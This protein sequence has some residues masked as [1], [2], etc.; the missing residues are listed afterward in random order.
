MGCFLDVS[1]EMVLQMP[2]H[3]CLE[4]SPLLAGSAVFSLFSLTP[5]V[6]RHSVSFSPDCDHA[7]HRPYIMHETC[8]RSSSS[9]WQRLHGSSEA[10]CHVFTQ[11]LLDH[12]WR[13][14]QAVALRTV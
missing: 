7:L 4:P 13:Q 8:R 14:V 5:C 3:S 1:M 10:F 9:A 11:S 6:V 12:L 2:D